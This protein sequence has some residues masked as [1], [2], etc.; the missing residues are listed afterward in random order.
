MSLFLKVLVAAAS[1]GAVFSAQAAEDRISS[2][3]DGNQAVLVKGFLRPRAT[4]ESDRGPISPSQALSG[5]TINVKLS[6]RQQSELDRLLEEQRDPSS[7]NYQKWLNPE[8]FGDRFGLSQSDMDKLTTWLRSHGFT[9]DHISRSMNWVAFSGTAAQVDRV[10]STDLHT[11]LV[12]GETHFANTK[13]PA[14]PSALQGVIGDIQGLNDFRLKPQRLRTKSLKPD[15]TTS[16]GSHY[17]APGDLAT[18]FNISPLYSAGFNGTG[19]K[20]VVAGQTAV[21]SSDIAAFRKQFGLPVSAPQMVLYGTNPGTTADQVEADLDLEWTGA[22]APNATIIYV[23]SNNVISSVQYAISQNL[24][25]VISLSYGGCEASNPSTMETIAQQ[26]NVQGITWLAASGDSGAAGCDGGNVATQGLAVNMPASIPEV[27]AVGGSEFNEGSGSYWSTANN[28]TGGSALSY[29]PEMAWNDSIARN[30]LASTGGGKSMY[31]VKPIWQTGTG[32]PADGARDIPDVSLPASPDHDGYYYY[33]A[34]AL[35]V[36]G[37]TSVSTPAFAGIVSILNQYLLSKGA[38]AKVGLANIN[39]TLYHLAAT[40]NNVFHDITVGSNIVP[41]TIGTKDC[42]NGSLGYAA[43]VGYDLAT[44]LGSVN[45]YN[46]VTNWSSLA[47]S[48]GTTTNLVAS[49]TSFI[50]TGSTTL[51]TTVKPATGIT[52]PTGSVVFSFGAK[53]LATVTLVASGSNGIAT[54]TVQGSSLTTGNDSLTATYGGS[55]AFTGSSAATTVTVTA[56]AIGTTTTVSA[57]P[58]SITTTSST[59]VTAAV[60]A[61]SGSA[62]PTGTVTFTVGAKTLGTGTLSAGTA[63]LTVTGSSLA[64]G[65]NTVTASY[66]A[67]IAFTGS[68]A[69]TTVTVTAP[70]ATTTA[71]SAN[72][73][74]IVNTASTT[75]TAVVKAASGSTTPA[76]TVTFTLGNKTLG[77]ATLSSGSAA[78]TVAGSALATGSNTITATYAATTAFTGSTGST[79]V[80]V[81]VLKPVAT[82]TTVAASLTSFTAS[83]GSTVLTVTV[84]PA[85]GTATPAGTITFSAGTKTVGTAT[86]N[87]SGTA[88]LTLKGTLLTVGTDTITVGYGGSRAF[89][90]STGT[91]ALILK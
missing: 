90:A 14:V 76:G 86:L 15:F 5:V 78:L 60:K 81:T 38:I 66:A 28:T 79:T 41:C 67:T 9:V 31:Y 56:A 54:L 32:V 47:S 36:V 23:Y 22:T 75:V 68:T 64:T 53:T 35:G 49:P 82:T 17:L 88:T 71:V 16:T 91:I 6:A 33:S 80:S 59:T 39:P 73:A 84:K 70:V 57:K 51:T 34:G 19:Q 12:D 69:S 65:S 18:I 40:T 13:R 52:A 62:T 8:E 20:L 10:F 72:P 42:P 2:R 50:S 45:A 27:T 29:I 1:F 87:G 3:I 11:F 25:P 44:G 26:A 83:T 4:T 63:S 58:A 61:A 77:T 37:G 85:S 24:A 7:A 30:D 21:A 55:A 74:S 46:M 43:G 89:A 48:I